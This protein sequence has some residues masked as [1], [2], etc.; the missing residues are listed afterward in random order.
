MKENFKNK[1]GTN[2][3]DIGVLMPRF[4]KSYFERLTVESVGYF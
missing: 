1:L 2:T 3:F 4:L